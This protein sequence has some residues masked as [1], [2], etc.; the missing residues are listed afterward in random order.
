MVDYR[1]PL[2]GMVTDYAMS[3]CRV[4]VEAPTPGLLSDWSSKAAAA[5]G[6]VLPAYIPS[7]T[8]PTQATM[9]TL[10][11]PTPGNRSGRRQLTAACAVL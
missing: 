5:A 1:V 3:A 8:N 11:P 10:L 4:G 7:G 2:V 6:T 9:L